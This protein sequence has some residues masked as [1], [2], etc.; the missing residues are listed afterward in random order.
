MQLYILAAVIAG[1]LLDQI[2]GDPKWMPHPVRAIGW[3]ISREEKAVRSFLPKTES[4]EQ[5]GGILFVFIVLFIVGAAVH[6]ILW[7]SGLI[8]PFVCFI[9]EAIMCYQMIA[10]RSLKEESMKVYSALKRAD[11]EEARASLSMIVGR[12]TESLN[13][14]QIIRAAVETVAE[15]TS[16]GVIAPLFYMMIGGP[17]CGFLYKAVNTMDSMVGYENDRYQYFG[18]C[19]SKLDDL[20]NFIPSRITA[21]IM[22]LSSFIL[23]YDGRN[24]WK[25][26]RRDRNKHKSPNA[27]QT[28]SACAGALDIELGGD[29]YYFGKLVVKSTFGD[30]LRKPQTEDIRKANRIMMLTSWLSLIIFSSVYMGI[31]LIF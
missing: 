1:F 17:V 15:N 18:T 2:L 8:R 31:C 19:A 5:L 7:V 14:G 6:L 26:F 29:A 28:E 25:I 22:I 9:I 12:D 16:D 27:G 10:A 21:L 30:D 4:G 3:L 24:A 23:R 13:E 20:L 11:T